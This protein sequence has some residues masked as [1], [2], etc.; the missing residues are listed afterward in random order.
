MFDK[1]PSLIALSFTASWCLAP[2][3]LVLS[4]VYLVL[5][6]SHLGLLRALM[7]FEAGLLLL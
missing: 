2:H 7:L 3:G 1:R 4:F 6:F 5:L